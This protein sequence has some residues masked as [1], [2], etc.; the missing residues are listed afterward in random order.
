MTIEDK[1]ILR[2]Q[3]A[4]Q[5]SQQIYEKLLVLTYSGGKDSDVTLD[6]A[7][8]A[9]IP[10]EAM[11]SL[12]TVDMPETVYHVR[13]VFAR[14]ESQGIPCK[15][16]KPT[17]KSAPV[18]MW[19]LIPQRD[20]PPTRLARYCCS[21]L[22]ETA[23]KGRFIAT[24]VRR[25]ESTKRASRESFEIIGS[26]KQ[27]GVLLSDDE[28]FMQDNTEKRMMFET[29]RP[30]AKRTVNPIIDWT[31]D[32]VWD[33]IAAEN[34]DVNPKYRDGYKRVGCI[35]CPLSGK[36]NRLREFEEYPTYK[37][38]YIRAFDEMLDVRKAKGLPTEWKTGSEVFEWW[39]SK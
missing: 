15:I 37:R 35:G 21:V 25:A 13:K 16:I 29:C 31:D 2:L 36:C 23:G 34:I 3:E 19:T 39:V 1:A 8:K 30:K 9:G 14:L 20:I 27:Y 5:M 24:G 22:K 32:D 6:L 33:Y 17:Y 4:A 18:T 7:I 38:A 12:T 10:F 26:R 11:H 28:A